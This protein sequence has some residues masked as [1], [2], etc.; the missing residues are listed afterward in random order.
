MSKWDRDRAKPARLG[1]GPPGD[2][3]PL[4]H[5]RGIVGVRKMAVG[6]LQ[7]QLEYMRNRV[8]STE[9][10]EFCIEVVKALVVGE[11]VTRSTIKDGG[12][13]G[14]PLPPLESPTLGK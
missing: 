4:K 1:P 13:G 6:V 9:E 12:N 10:R 5:S 7:Q 11:K 3:P 14:V 8:L 2:L